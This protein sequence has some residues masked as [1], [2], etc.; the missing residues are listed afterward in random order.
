MC[1]SDL[2]LELRGT[3]KLEETVRTNAVPPA[4]DDHTAP[5]IELPNE[6]KPSGFAHT[7]RVAAKQR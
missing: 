1:S 7:R 5:Y 2:L 4:N 3:A 6:V